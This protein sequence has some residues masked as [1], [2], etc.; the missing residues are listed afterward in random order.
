MMTLS[1]L[2][3]LSKYTS[4]EK[5]Q[6]VDYF[7]SFQSSEDGLFYD[8]TVR[9]GIY[10]DTD[11]WGARHLALHLISAYTMLDASPKYPFKFLERYYDLEGFGYY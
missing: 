6:W 10:D 4:E 8:Q 3:E 5:R 11:W 1:H 9:N 7:D 2:N